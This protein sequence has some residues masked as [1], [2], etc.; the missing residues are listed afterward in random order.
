MRKVIRMY[1]D[2]YERW[3]GDGFYPLVVRHGPCQTPIDIEFELYDDELT[4]ISGPRLMGYDADTKEQII[5]I[6]LESLFK[7]KQD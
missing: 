4:Q 1:Y 5:K 2:S 7:N 3:N 6:M